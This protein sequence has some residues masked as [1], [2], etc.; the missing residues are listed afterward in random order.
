M[1]SWEKDPDVHVRVGLRLTGEDIDMR[2]LRGVSRDTEDG[3]VLRDEVIVEPEGEMD[4]LLGQHGLEDVPGPDHPH[5][6][7]LAHFHLDFSQ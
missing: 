7:R 5:H 1:A 4:F 6:R 3:V 2:A